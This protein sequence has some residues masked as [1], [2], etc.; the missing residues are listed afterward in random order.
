MRHS[1]EPGDVGEGR[2]LR[3]DTESKPQFQGEKKNLP[4]D[5]TRL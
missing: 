3:K 4:V 5:F 2:E 1:N